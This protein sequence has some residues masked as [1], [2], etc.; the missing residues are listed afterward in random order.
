MTASGAHFM[1]HHGPTQT[2][3]LIV[4][5][6][7][8]C[9][10]GTQETPSHQAVNYLQ[11]GID[12]IKSGDFRGAEGQLQK[13]IRLDPRNPEAYNLLG[14]V[15]DQTD[16][17]LQAIQYYEEALN[18]APTFSAAR[19]NLGS[20]YLRMGKTSLAVEQFEKTLRYRPDDLTANYDLGLI[21]LQT[22]APAKS[23]AHLEKAHSLAPN[24]SA[25]FFILARNYFAAGRKED[26]LDRKST[27]L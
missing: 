2:A 23:V 8:A 6:L 22:G 27:R 9:F 14:F 20:A 19:N 15:S 4:A 10:A 21:C 7:W 1:M 5:A 24:D 26:G 12:E 18:L 16:R 11:A 3:S 13:A 25:V 17:T